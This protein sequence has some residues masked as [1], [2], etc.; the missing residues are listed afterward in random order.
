MWCSPFPN[1]DQPSAGRCRVGLSVVVLASRLPSWRT[2][3][4]HATTSTF[5]AINE[6]LRNRE[7]TDGQAVTKTVSVHFG[8]ESE[9]RH[10]PIGWSRM[11]CVFLEGNGI[12]STHRSVT[13]RGGHCSCSQERAY[14]PIFYVR[15]FVCLRRREYLGEYLQPLCVL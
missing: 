7:N 6:L 15:A 4:T 9:T 5:E 10:Y 14:R 8:T 12:H 3:L 2:G 13:L 1:G 11:K